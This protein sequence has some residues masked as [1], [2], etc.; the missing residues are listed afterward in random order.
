[1]SAYK[2]E[3]KKS[4]LEANLLV[5]LKIILTLKGRYKISRYQFLSLF[6]ADSI[7]FLTN[8]AGYIWIKMREGAERKQKVHLKVLLLVIRN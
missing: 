2:K 8:I 3:S 4:E 6:P 7:R 1:L 5:H